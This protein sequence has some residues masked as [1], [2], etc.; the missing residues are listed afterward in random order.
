MEP[1][2]RQVAE[3]KGTYGL[4]LLF[5]G[6]PLYL[7]LSQVQI[8]VPG[9]TKSHGMG[10]LSAGA[11][12][13]RLI[14]LSSVPHTH[15]RWIALGFLTW[16]IASLTMRGVAA[17]ELYGP[18]G[19]KP[20]A[21]RQGTL[22]SCYFHAVIAALA[23]SR[24]D[25][26]RGMIAANSD[27]TYTVKFADDSKENA[28]LEDIRYARQSGYDLSEGLWVAVLFRAYAQRVLREELLAEIEKSDLFPFAKPY[29]KDFVATHDS[30][31]LA[32]DRA[33]RSQV[34]QNGNIDRKRL[35]SR[36]REEIKPLSV[37]DLVSESVIKLLE[38]EGFFDSIAQLVK[39]NGEIFGAYRAAGQG[40]VAE[41]VMKTM[42]GSNRFIQNGTESQTAAALEEAFRARRPVVACS[43]GSLFARQLAEGKALPPDTRNWYLSAHCYTAL[44]YDGSGQTVTLRN[45][46]ASFPAPDGVFT[47]PLRTF[48]P[49]FRGIITTE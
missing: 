27:G 30:L 23:H 11:C 29:V 38:S 1:S 26:L 37:P 4:R 35:E 2:G 43:G 31:L 18:P 8:R 15:L 47:V 14:V 17:D 10:A 6:Q 40:G 24:P 22:G 28:Y 44:S 5:D 13:T 41:Q 16:S 33:I 12:G 9:T 42:T 45:P 34:E 25:E 39:Q 7:Y 3:N 19:V 32:Y 46:W 21:V 36:L 48:T 49:A 20:E